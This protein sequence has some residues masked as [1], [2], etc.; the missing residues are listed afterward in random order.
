MCHTP[1]TYAHPMH[2]PAGKLRPLM[3][4][5]ILW[6]AAKQ[7][8]LFQHAH[9]VRATDAVINGDVHAFVAEVVCDG[10][11]LDA[12]PFGQ[13]VADEVHAPD[14]IDEAALMQRHAIETQALHATV[15]A[16]RQVDQ[17][18]EPIRALVAVR[19]PAARSKSAMSR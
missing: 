16:Y 3:G 15:L 7:S 14:F 12:S 17:L 2:A 4:S 1:L 8:H 5:H 9:N 18:V 13:A 10:Q 11:A 6:I 19:V